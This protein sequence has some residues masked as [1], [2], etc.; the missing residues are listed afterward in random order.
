MI[1]AA[2]R[3]VS[4]DDDYRIIE[5][6]GIPFGGP[7]A[8]R[9]SYGTYASVRT[10]FVWGLFPDLIPGATRSTD[11]PRYIRP[12]TYNHGFDPDIGLTRL[13]GWSPVRVDADGVWVQAQIDKRE[14]Y[15]ARVAALL[16]KEQLGFSVDSAEHSVRFD[17]HTGEWLAWP[18]YG[19]ALTPTESNP[20][21]IIASRSAEVITI[22]SASRRDISADERK[23]IPA[24]DFAGPDRT[25]PIAQPED[26]A[27]AARSVRRAADSDA[28]KAKIISIAKRKGADFEA[29]LPEAWKDGGSSTKTAMR[30]SLAADNAAWGASILSSMLSVLSCEADEPDEA[31]MIQ[32]AIDAWNEWLNAERAEI[33]T[34]EDIAD[35]AE[36]GM[37]YMS[38]TRAGKRNSAVDQT[39]VDSIHDATVA[40]GA[41]AH[42]DS[43]A[44]D[45]GSARS[46]EAPPGTLHIVASPERADAETLRDLAA[47]LAGP[48]GESVAHRMLDPKT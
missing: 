21:A 27:G 1:I 39:S 8:G 37:A 3:T 32:S 47:R 30:M 13:G 9:D 4:E 19:L 33:G 41:T 7:F 10:D 16:D 46:A 18:A 2:V 23:A 44:A 20:Y 25:F 17:E 22:L 12:L 42:Y 38:A 43:T 15:Y 36:G 11:E 48:V 35:S 5:G 6:R 29:Q 40:L 26:V 34:P 45:D 24:A 14:K 31:A 28:V